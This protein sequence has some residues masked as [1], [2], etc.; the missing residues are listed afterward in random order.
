MCSRELSSVRIV[1][2]TETKKEQQ[3][4]IHYC[5]RRGLTLAETYRE[6]K[7]VYGEECFQLQMCEQWH[8]DFKD[9]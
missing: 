1:M 4:V 3:Y 2:A 6:M 9:G 8:N 7:D 5:Y